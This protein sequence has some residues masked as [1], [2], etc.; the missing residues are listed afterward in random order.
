MFMVMK[1][2]FSRCYQF[3]TYQMN[4]TGCS[5]PDRDEYG[6][7]L[8]QPNWGG[9]LENVEVLE[10]VRHCHKPDRTKESETCE[11]RQQVIFTHGKQIRLFSLV[12]AVS[13]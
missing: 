10:D 1:L 13:C 5:E 8:G 12:V 3:Q 4:D 6:D 9:S 11:K 2:Y 7:Q